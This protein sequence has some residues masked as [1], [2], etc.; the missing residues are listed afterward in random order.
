MSEPF[1]SIVTPSHNRAEMIHEAVKSVLA[2]A[3]TP[4]EHI[5][6]DG[7]ST[8]GTLDVLR[9]Y[10][11]LQVLSEPDSGMYEAINK[12]LRVARG[13]IV[14]LLNTD[15]LYASG[16]FSAVV[17]A[18]A[19]HPEALAAVGGAQIFSTTLAGTQLIREDPP[20]RPDEFWQRVIQGHPVTNAWFFRA[21][22]FERVGPMDTGYRFA[23][24][25]EFLIRCALAGVRPT[26]IPMILYRYRQ[27]PGSATISVEGSREAKRGAQRLLVLGEGMRLLEGFLAQQGIPSD[28]RGHLRDAHSATCYRAA[29]TAFYH[30]RFKIGFHAVRQGLRH[31]PLWLLVFGRR[32]WHRLL[33]EF[34]LRQPI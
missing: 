4:C 10:P 2:Q 28:V 18:F 3:Y 1:I 32:A 20:I 5:I 33:Q 15:D 6:V 25:R 21:E 16:A 30:R 17:D 19:E 12:G 26:P 29:A 23:A 14:G 31:D 34:G 22:V 13:E 8:D 7:A 24:D 27:H 11:H 9:E